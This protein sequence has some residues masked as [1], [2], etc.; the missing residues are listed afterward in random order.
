MKFFTVFTKQGR[1][2]IPIKDTEERAAQEVARNNE[3]SLADK[4]RELADLSNKL[5]KTRVW[6]EGNEFQKIS[7]KDVDGRKVVIEKGG[8]GSGSWEGPDQPRYA[9]VGSGKHMA[10]DKV[11]VIFGTGIA[12]GKTGTV[13]SSS[14]IKT[15]G[16]GIPT[17]VEGAY[18]PVDWKRET[19][20]RYDDG[21]YDTLEHGRL[22]PVGH[23]EAQKPVPPVR[24]ASPDDFGSSTRG[25][26]GDQR[27]VNEH[28]TRAA[29]GKPSSKEDPG[30]VQQ[31]RDADA[32]V[33]AAK[34]P[35][36]EDMVQ[37]ILNHYKKNPKLDTGI[38]NVGTVGSGQKWWGSVGS[39]DKNRA[40]NAAHSILHQNKKSIDSL[41]DLA[42]KIQ[43]KKS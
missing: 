26:K 39:E 36:H 23:P 27:P 42:G 21:K 1:I 37:D 6:A 16:R 28:A 9:H 40:I 3:M 18:K 33:R 4:V 11:S 24:S 35:S 5:T 34:T 15:D 25:S 12:S 43:K 8:P 30:L 14:E 31:V 13:V 7:F 22:K 41:R 19:A 20:I 10:G 29:Q 2:E 17:N 38:S 32:K